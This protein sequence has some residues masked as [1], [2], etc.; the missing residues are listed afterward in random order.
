M[1]KVSKWFPA[2]TKLCGKV[3]LWFLAESCTALNMQ[4][5]LEKDSTSVFFS[6]HARKNTTAMRINHDV[7]YRVLRDFRRKR[8]VIT[9]GLGA[10][11]KRLLMSQRKF[12]VIVWRSSPSIFVWFDPELQRHG[13]PQRHSLAHY[14][15]LIYLPVK[16]SLQ[17][18][19]SK[20]C[21]ADFSRTASTVPSG[22][23][24]GRSG[25]LLL[26]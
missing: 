9:R 19:K 4:L 25:R 26:N 18:V 5:C 3:A 20:P 24:P 13:H 2:E 12:F 8:A 15:L 16:D 14:R 23:R 11:R 6:F 21:G 7:L 22:C 17:Y 1:P 10:W